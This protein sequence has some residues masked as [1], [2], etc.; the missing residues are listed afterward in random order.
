M[1][2]EVIK[3]LLELGKKLGFE[4]RTEVGA[5]GSAWVDVAWLDK[6]FRYGL[7]KVHMWK[8]PLVAVV[9][10][11]VEAN[12]E[13]KQVKGSV[14]NL[15]NLGALLGVIVLTKENIDRMRRENKSDA[16][17]PEGKLWEKLKKFVERWISE[18]RPKT[19]ILIMTEDDVMNWAKLE[20]LEGTTGQG[21]P[22]AT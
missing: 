10:F 20:G 12:A 4:A 1:K 13:S 14:A 5:S 18:A 17:K 16:K 22:S 9:G 2:D 15:E 21:G 11:E 19:R 6:R 8:Y 7:E 3:T